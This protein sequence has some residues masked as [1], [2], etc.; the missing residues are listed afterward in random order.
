LEVTHEDVNN[1]S[2]CDDHFEDFSTF[3]LPTTEPSI[4]TCS[5]ITEDVHSEIVFYETI[6]HDDDQPAVLEKVVE[7]VTEEVSC[8]S[9]TLTHSLARLKK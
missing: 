7:H 6:S 2:Y 4:D 3:S 8:I 5:T 9:L 1:S